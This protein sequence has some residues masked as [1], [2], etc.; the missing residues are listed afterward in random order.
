MRRPTA[1]S[2][3]PNNK[4]KAHRPGNRK[5]KPSAWQKS[6]AFAAMG[7]DNLSWFHRHRHEFQKCGA[8]AKSSGQP[9]KQLALPNGRCRWHGGLT[10][11]GD[12]WGRRQVRPKPPRKQRAS[13]WRETEAKLKKWQRA[14]QDRIRRLRAMTDEQFYAWIRRVGRR[15]EDPFAP[16]LRR[17]VRDELVKRGPDPTASSTL[18]GD[19][20]ETT[21]PPSPEI[22]ALDAEIA[23]LR[24]QLADDAPQNYGPSPDDGEQSDADR[25][26]CLHGVFR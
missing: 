12:D 17:A 18:P 19:S 21:R 24:Q 20:V 8:H 3:A 23:R 1:T 14:D 26:S 6:A 4:K 25:V 11:A 2:T 16:A 5:R 10:P 9:C 22:A 13:D 7:A 15:I